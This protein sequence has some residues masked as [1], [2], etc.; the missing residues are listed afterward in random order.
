MAATQLSR[1]E[2]AR[3]FRDGETPRGEDFESIFLSSLNKT[4]DGVQLNGQGHLELT[5]GGIRLNATPNGE[6]GT[7]R[8]VGTSLQYHDG[9]SF[10]TLSTGSGGAFVPI[11]GSTNVA[12]QGGNVGIGPFETSS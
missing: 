5:R 3:I 8:F 2:L 4:D 9:T 1:S 11:G 12:F 7:L 6:G 10:R